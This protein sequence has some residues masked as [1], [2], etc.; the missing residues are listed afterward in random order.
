MGEILNLDD[1]EALAIAVKIREILITTGRI[2]CICVVNRDGRPLVQ[3]AMSMAKSFTRITALRKARQSAKTGKTTRQ[4]RD[5]VKEGSVTPHTYDIKL[6]HFVKWAGG[7][8]IYDAN[9]NLLGGVGVSGLEE[10]EDEN[11]AILGVE[12]IDFFHTIERN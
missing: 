8:P 9:K 6:E 5:S 11:L 10:D 1:A 12:E 7:V 2:A 4:L 3:I